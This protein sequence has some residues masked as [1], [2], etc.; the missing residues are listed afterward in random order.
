MKLQDLHEAVDKSKA[1]VVKQQTVVDALAAKVAAGENQ[2]KVYNDDIGWTMVDTTAY[3]QIQY[4]KSLAMMKYA[5]GL[6]GLQDS[7]Q[8]VL[9]ANLPSLG[10]APVVNYTA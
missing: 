4:D 2:I 10:E 6:S 3:W 5:G 1:D 9:D 7:L 8:S